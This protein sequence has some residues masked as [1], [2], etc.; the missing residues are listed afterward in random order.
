MKFVTN[1]EEK[2]YEKFVSHNKKS[3]FMQSYYWGEVMKYK[4]FIPHYVGIK[5]NDILFAINGQ[6]FSSPMEAMSILNQHSNEYITY[7]IIRNN[8]ILNFDIWVY[9]LINVLFLISYF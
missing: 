9:K 1:I 3:H 8:Q 7:T 6:I 5:E 4:N 2:E